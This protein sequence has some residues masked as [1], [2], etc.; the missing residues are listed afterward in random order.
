MKGKRRLVVVLALLAGI[1]VL[2]G[3]VL[4]LKGRQE[5]LRT[6]PYIRF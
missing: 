5:E 4:V 6:R 1:L 3:F 2:G